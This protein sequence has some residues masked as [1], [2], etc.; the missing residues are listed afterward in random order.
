MRKLETK[1]IAEKKKRRN[2]WIIGVIL[3]GVMLFSTLGYAFRGRDNAEDNTN[4]GE[5]SSTNYH[6]QTFLFQNGLWMI[7]KGDLVF[8]FKNLPNDANLDQGLDKITS[9]V[10]KPL[11]VYSENVDAEYEVY[12]NLDQIVLRRQGAC[13]EGKECVG[14]IPT[15]TCNDNFIIIEVGEYP[16]ITQQDHCV[17]ITGPQDSL[18]SLTDEFLLEAIGISN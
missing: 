14:D 11:Y 16:V 4:P 8:S 17:F 18:E 5:G 2:Q 13:P 6:G 3:V 1:E 15:K 10:N 7:Q 12:R 9:Y